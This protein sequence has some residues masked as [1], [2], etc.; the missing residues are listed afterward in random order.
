MAPQGSRL[1]AAHDMCWWNSGPAG[2]Q[3]A[4]G[5]IPT[6][7]LV[8]PLVDAVVV[9]LQARGPLPGSRI[10]HALR[11]THGNAIRDARQ[12]HT[13]KGW[14]RQILCDDPRITIVRD[15]GR[16]LGEPWFA[17]TDAVPAAGLA[18]C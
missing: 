13:G 2:L 16:G 1:P 6:G 5:L 3:P 10:Q 8:A 7:P 11:H 15:A 9:L 12:L 4:P 14:M 18:G 17:V